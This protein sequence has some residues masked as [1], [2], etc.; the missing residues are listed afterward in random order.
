MIVDGLSVEVGGLHGQAQRI[1]LNSHFIQH[2]HLNAYQVEINSAGCFSSTSIVNIRHLIGRSLV[3]GSNLN[4]DELNTA[5]RHR[6][7]STA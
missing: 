6:Q 4:R 1:I 7:S 3:V 5:H 2:N